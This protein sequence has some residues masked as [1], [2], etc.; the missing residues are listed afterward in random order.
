MKLLT[1]AILIVVL[2]S[3]VPQSG[4]SKKSQIQDK[5][6]QNYAG[7]KLLD[8]EQDVF[9]N[10]KDQNNGQMS[11]NR[12]VD[13]EQ[14]D[15]SK[16]L[17]DL[18]PQSG[19]SCREWLESQPEV[20]EL[21][22][23]KVKISISGNSTEYVLNNSC[24]YKID[25]MGKESCQDLPIDFKNP[26]ATP[27]ANCVDQE[28]SAFKLEFEIKEVNDQSVE[29]KNATVV[30]D[31]ILAYFKNITSKYASLGINVDDY[32]YRLAQGYGDNEGYKESHFLQEMQ[33][34]QGDEQKN[35][36]VGSTSQ[37]FQTQNVNSNSTTQLEQRVIVWGHCSGSIPDNTLIQ[38]G[39]DGVLDSTAVPNTVDWQFS[40]DN[41]SRKC[42]Y[43]CKSGYVYQSM[44]KTC[45]V[46]V[47]PPAPQK[48]I[49][50]LKEIQNELSNEMKSVAMF[51]VNAACINP[52]SGERGANNWDSHDSTDEL[53]LS[54]DT[55]WQHFS[56]DAADNKCEFHC[57]M[58]RGWDVATSSCEI[59][60][61]G[62]NEQS[63]ICNVDNSNLEISDTT[64]GLVSNKL[65]TNSGYECV[66]NTRS[67]KID[68]YCTKIIT[69]QTSDF[70][71]NDISI[72]QNWYDGKGYW[73]EGEK[74]IITIDFPE[75][76]LGFIDPDGDRVEGRCYI[77][78]G[79]KFV[80]LV[81]GE[82]KILDNLAKSFEIQ[83][84][85]YLPGKAH[86]VYIYSDGST[87][88][89]YNE[90]NYLIV[91]NKTIDFS[92]RKI[93]QVEGNIEFSTDTAINGGDSVDYKYTA[94]N[95]SVCW[96][97][98]HFPCQK[99]ASDNDGFYSA[100]ETYNSS[101]VGSTQYNEY[102]GESYGIGST[103]Y[104][105]FVEGF[106]KAPG[107]LNSSISKSGSIKIKSP[108]GVNASMQLKCLGEGHTGGVSISNENGS[109]ET[110]PKKDS[111]GKFIEDINQ[112]D[113]QKYYSFRNNGGIRGMEASY[114]DG[115]HPFYQ[116][117][118]TFNTKRIGKPE[119]VEFSAS[120]GA[121]GEEGLQINVKDNKVDS[122]NVN[123]V[124]FYQVKHSKSCKLEAI[125]QNNSGQD[126]TVVL[127]NFEN[128]QD[129]NKAEDKSDYRKLFQQNL[130]F[131]QGFSIPSSYNLTQ[132]YFEENF[133]VSLKCRNEV[134]DFQELKVLTHNGASTIA[135]STYENPPE[136]TIENEPDPVSFPQS[137][138]QDTPDGETEDVEEVVQNTMIKC[139]KYNIS[140]Q[141]NTTNVQDISFTITEAA[142]N[143]PGSGASDAID[144]CIKAIS[145][146]TCVSG[147]EYKNV[148][149]LT[150]V[151][152]SAPTIPEPISISKGEKLSDLS[153]NATDGTYCKTK[154]GKDNGIL[155]L[156][157]RRGS[158]GQVK[159]LRALTPTTGSSATTSWTLDNNGYIK[160]RTNGVE[161]YSEG[162]FDSGSLEIASDLTC[163]LKFKKGEE[164][165]LDK[166]QQ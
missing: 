133:R 154:I 46:Y 128:N 86:A 90:A 120:F 119:L 79:Y 84:N 107:P 110:Y 126:I 47:E 53:D 93:D 148:N 142:T 135:Y 103:N 161:T 30:P 51:S 7:N 5:T 40:Q 21:K 31:W 141:F 112:N 164:T 85:E 33:S 23:A 16:V 111:A 36:D 96:I 62:K 72:T 153:L 6:Q 100:C 66:E 73:Y 151:D 78:G 113:I 124:G 156:Q 25:F 49:E 34:L 17:F 48:N 89:W 2:T 77:P 88:D 76:K 108:F 42:E 157:Y 101:P 41:T 12:W 91:H 13:T 134:Y 137:Q 130:N 150:P 80:Q 147:Y 81:P 32:A 143:S 70:S 59:C 26:V 105:R 87:S 121:N 18:Y 10:F 14:I 27:V 125:Y 158:N 166:V 4:G 54:Q 145:N 115:K 122:V 68:W 92:Y 22:S 140:G 74:P 94:K 52:P 20:N 160:A 102:Y 71:V 39:D 146:V 144:K 3:C 69:D 9:D 109:T 155:L 15:A 163:H 63:D 58:N 57:G 35:I 104:P 61:N 159:T 64:L 44:S 75:D 60:S 131:T 97:D 129:N 118:S 127:K 116:G 11:L 55:N 136:T 123:L 29:Q 56:V 139:T 65:Y 132:T 28:Y 82:Q 95:V 38:R 149:C 24:P 165:L 67:T 162:I 45:T 37:L 99:E 8:T 43:K 98:V 117:G 19:M 106:G 50:P 1:W 138:P 114:S 83:C 152:S